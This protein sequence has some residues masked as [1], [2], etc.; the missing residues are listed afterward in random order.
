MERRDWTWCRQSRAANTFLPSLTDLDKTRSLFRLIFNLDNLP[1]HPRT[2][3]NTFPPYSSHIDDDTSPFGCSSF[4]ALQMSVFSCTTQII[5]FHAAEW[6]HWLS[7]HSGLWF[8]H[9][10]CSGEFLSSNITE[11]TVMSSSVGLFPSSPS[12]GSDTAVSVDNEDLTLKAALFIASSRPDR[13]RLKGHGVSFS[14][15]VCRSH[16]AMLSSHSQLKRCIF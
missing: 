1:N 13:H 6:K 3:W 9:S 7:I 15:P 2:D 16:A 4:R 8:H 14:P 10:T 11:I 5:H 12:L